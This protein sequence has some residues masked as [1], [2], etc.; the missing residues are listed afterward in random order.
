MYLGDFRLGDTL[1]FGF[2]TVQSTGA[3][4]TL[5]GSPVISAYP[6]NS[7]TELT[8][9]ITLSVD[10]DSR[11]GLNNVRIV[12]TSGNGYATATNYKVVITTGTV[13]SISAVGYVVAHFSIENRS[14]LMPTTAARTLVVDAAGLSDANVVKIGP[15]GAGTAQV[16]RDLGTSVLLSAGTGTGQLDLTSGIPKVNLAQILGTAL[17]ETAGQ[18][19]AG[20][21]KFFNIATP[22][23][24]M[25]HGILVDTVTTATTATN[26][27]TNNDKTGYSIA[28]GGITRASLAA[29][30][31]LQTSRS[32]T[33]Q[34]GAATTITL[35]GS[36][37]AVDSFYVGEIV[38]L[39]GGTGAGQARVITGYVGATK[40]ATVNRAWATNP[41]NTST[42]GLIARDTN[43]VNALLEVIAASVSAGGITAPSFGVGAVDAAALNADAATEIVTAIFARTF[44][45]A[46]SS[47]NLDAV[48]SAIFAAV[49]GVTSGAGTGTEVF[50]G[51]D[52]STTLVTTT[53]DG[54]NRTG[55]TIA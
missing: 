50:K 33:A 47:K 38:Y 28:T 30:T 14:A 44:G 9:G 2:C 3:P 53:N 23:A 45:A 55:S 34:A 32:S 54:T 19:A 13:N 25:D 12:A 36:A 7:T 1:D 31:G 10:F 26:L 4:T 46:L 48:L 18:I 8:A 51:S 43:K 21:K 40:V 49:A 29:D 39:T 6:G 37:S 42:F 5:S 15:T 27:T 20:F 22:A 24:T 41:D 17:T 11:T 35:D 52:G 16:A